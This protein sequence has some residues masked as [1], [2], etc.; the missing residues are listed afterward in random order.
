MQK[1]EINNFGPISNVTIELGKVTLLI[2]EQA[3]GK[4]T[5]SQLV[6]FF[7][8]LKE[9]FFTII[10]NRIGDVDSEDKL[11]EAFFREIRR[12]FY[13][14]FGSTKHLENFTIKFYYSKTKT[15]QL[16]LNPNKALKCNF[17][18]TFFE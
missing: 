6:Y 9:D 8:S 4:S 7:K 12:K 3:T 16:S 11:Q 13:N 10:F 17:D 18:N 1:I 15:I 14:F 5:V 2:G